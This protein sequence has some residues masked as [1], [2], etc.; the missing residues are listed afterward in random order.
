MDMS[1]KKFDI[2][3]KVNNLDKQEVYTWTRDKFEERFQSMKDLFSN[4]EESG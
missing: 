4:Y 1:E 3:V 2:E